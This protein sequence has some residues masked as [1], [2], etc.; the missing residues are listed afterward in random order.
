MQEHGLNFLHRDMGPKTSY[1]AGDYN[2]TEYL[3]QDPTPAGK[4][5]SSSVE[6]ALRKDLAASD[7]SISQMVETAWASA[8]TFRASDNRGGANGV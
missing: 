2:P 8:S 6:D 5:L 3:W 7:L 1:V 4:A